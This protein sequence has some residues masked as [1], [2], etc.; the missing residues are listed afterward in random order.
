MGDEST[1]MHCG[2][3]NWSTRVGI[4]HREYRPNCNGAVG[5]WRGYGSTTEPPEASVPSQTISGGGTFKA[6]IR[7]V[8]ST[9][10]QKG[11]KLQRFDLVP[12]G[13]L[14]RLAEHYGRGALKYSDHNWRKGYE[15]SKSYAALLRHLTAWWNGEEYDV[16]PSSGDGC[17][18]VTVEGEPFEGGGTANGGTC[19]NH[20]GGHHLD[21]VKFHT[22]ALDEWR[23][24][25]P[26][27]DDRW[28]GSI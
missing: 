28:K 25:H 17:S 2:S 11:T 15:W 6:E 26:E 10:G 1:Y 20:T 19:Y 12:I 14:T 21:G 5:V 4:S 18:F 9:G 13:P 16:C 22:F 24:T 3:C 23:E 27:F 8:S 7:T